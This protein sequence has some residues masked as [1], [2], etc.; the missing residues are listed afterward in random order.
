MRKSRPWK[1]KSPDYRDGFGSPKWRHR[2]LELAHTATC[3]REAALTCLQSTWPQQGTEACLDSWDSCDSAHQERVFKGAI[4]WQ[5]LSTGHLSLTSI[6]LCSDDSC[7]TGIA[8]TGWRNCSSPSRDQN[9]N[10]F[11][12]LTLKLPMASE[13]NAP[14]KN[15]KQFAFYFTCK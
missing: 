3:L 1:I 4:S 5:V 11:F 9:R 7:A 13:E 8:A 14:F 2:K 6:H 10:G 15:R 12:L